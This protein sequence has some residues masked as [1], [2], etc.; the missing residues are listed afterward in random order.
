M[1]DEH[2]SFQLEGLDGEK[3]ELEVN[4]SNHK[5]V[6]DCQLIKF[7]L[8]DNEVTVKRDH[9]TSL[10]MMIGRPQDQK[11]LIP[12]KL[13]NIRKLERMLTFEWNASKDYKKGDKIT[14][15]APWID[16]VP[17]VEEIFAGNLEKRKKNPLKFFIK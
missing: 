12:M 3:I 8:G 13:T 1:I 15:K 9:F 16:E 11:K 7:K 4:W 17:D 14:V 2:R 6:K 10:L 5:D